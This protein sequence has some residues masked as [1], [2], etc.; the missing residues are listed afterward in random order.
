MAEYP[1][2][3]L[4]KPIDEEGQKQGLLADRTRSKPA[5]PGVLPISGLTP[6]I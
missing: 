6:K 1:Q 4:L 5:S 2:G 3:W